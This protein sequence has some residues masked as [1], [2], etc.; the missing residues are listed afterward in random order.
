M[1]LQILNICDIILNLF[2]LSMQKYLTS[3]FHYLNQ[4]ESG[5]SRTGLILCGIY[6]VFALY[7]MGSVATCAPLFIRCGQLWFVMSLPLSVLILPFF[8]R[9]TSGLYVVAF[10][11][12]SIFYLVTL[13][14]VGRIVEFIRLKRLTK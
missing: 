11:L 7:L 2:Y 3:I 9:L 1:D 14:Q 12:S 10:L 5:W 8:D 6:L 4:R 13:Y